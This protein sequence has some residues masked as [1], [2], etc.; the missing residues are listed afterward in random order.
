MYSCFYL[1]VIYQSYISFIFHDISYHYIG[2]C[3]RFI[4]I[5]TL[6]HLSVAYQQST[7]FSDCQAYSGEPKWHSDDFQ[8]S[9]G[10][11]PGVYSILVHCSSFPLY[12]FDQCRFIYVIYD[13]LHFSRGIVS[14][15]MV[16]FPHNS[17]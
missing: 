14:P 1:T 5:P 2:K 11:I 15:N 17:S 16:G 12:R 6:Q 10:P 3:C 7:G 4:R 9:D 13:P 8:R